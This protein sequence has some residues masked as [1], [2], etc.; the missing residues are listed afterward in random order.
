MRISIGELLSV[1]AWPER[2]VTNLKKEE[3]DREYRNAIYK[4]TYIRR[5]LF[6]KHEPYSITSLK[7][8]EEI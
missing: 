6:E 5:V 2:Q 3:K 4:Q 7:L 1:Q 8:Y